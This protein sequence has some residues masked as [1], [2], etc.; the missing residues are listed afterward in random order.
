[1]MIDVDGLSRILGPI[2]AHHLYV[3]ALFH[4]I[5]V[6]KKT[7]AYIWKLANTPA[8][9]KIVQSNDEYSTTIPILISSL[10]SPLSNPTIRILLQ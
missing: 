1:M 3:T 2:V 9:T 4:K 6:A 8:D 10:I 7:L 5:G